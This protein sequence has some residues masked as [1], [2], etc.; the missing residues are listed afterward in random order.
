MPNPWLFTLALAGSLANAQDVLINAPYVE[1][2]P[3]IVTAMLQMAKTR[4]KDVVYDLGCGDGRIVIAAARRFGAHGVCID[5]YPEHIATARRNAARAGVSRLIEFRV[6]DLFDA[7]LRPATIVTLY[8]L[9]EV[10]RRLRPK[11][12]RELRPGARIVSHSFDMG[13]WPPL[14]RIALRGSTLYYWVVPRRAAGE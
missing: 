5:L 10:N 3:D 1:T 13:D 2:P 11:L 12:L 14:R 8:L 4:R 7:D 9:P 6:G